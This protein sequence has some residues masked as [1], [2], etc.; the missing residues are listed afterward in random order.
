MVQGASC[1]K[2]SGGDLR[3]EK[4]KKKAGLVVKGNASLALPMSLACYFSL[5]DSDNDDIR[6]RGDEKGEERMMGATRECSS[7]L[8]PQTACREKERERKKI[9]K[10]GLGGAPQ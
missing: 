4:K 3:E 6:E 2:Q 9:E 8:L 1:K 5:Y 10:D 7:I